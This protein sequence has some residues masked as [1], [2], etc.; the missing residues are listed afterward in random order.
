MTRKLHGQ[1]HCTVTSN[2]IVMLEGGPLVDASGLE[3][4]L[5][6][7]LRPEGLCKDDACVIVSDHEALFDGERIDITAVASLLD[8]PATTDTESG[9]VAIGA[10]REQRRAAINDMKAPDF[11]LPNIDGLPMNFS[12]HRSKKRL[13]VAFS[14]W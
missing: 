10:P 4:A 5:G 6:W 14:S 7:A 13:L 3:D 8:R 2:D 12:D 11:V 9:L 1:Y